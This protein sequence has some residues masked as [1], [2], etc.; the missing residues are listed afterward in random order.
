ME[1]AMTQGQAAGIWVR[2]FNSLPQSVIEKLIKS[3]DEVVEITPYNDE[4]D[5]FLPLWGMMW[6]FDVAIDNDW[7]AK[8]CNQ[9]LMAECGF[10]IYEQEDYGYIFGIDGGGYD[11]YESHWIPL[12][13]VRGLAWHVDPDDKLLSQPAR[14]ER[15]TR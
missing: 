13:K 3:G 1:K 7:L 6:S 15:T 11:F 8:K 4:K 2:G 9:K 5:S 10:R 14:L 12:Y